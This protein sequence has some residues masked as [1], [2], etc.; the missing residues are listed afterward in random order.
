MFYDVA[1][2]F[3][4]HA[5]FPES[6]IKPVCNK[7]EQS[8]RIGEPFLVCPALRLLLCQFDNLLSA[9]GSRKPCL[10]I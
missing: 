1:F 3:A 5:F 7:A 9:L 10:I 4:Y 6:E 8:G 2:A